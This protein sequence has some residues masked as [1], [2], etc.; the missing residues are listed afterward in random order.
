LL[1]GIAAFVSTSPWCTEAAAYEAPPT[2]WLGT[3]MARQD[4]ARNVLECLLGQRELKGAPLVV[5]HSLGGL[6]VKQ[7]LSTAGAPTGRPRRR[8]SIP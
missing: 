2:N 4:C 6:V 7:V 8:L 5:C 3:G 1:I